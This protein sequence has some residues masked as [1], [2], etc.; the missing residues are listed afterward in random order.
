MDPRP[1][2]VPGQHLVVLLSRR[3]ALTCCFVCLRTDFCV[4]KEEPCDTVGKLPPC[5]HTHWRPHVF[6]PVSCFWEEWGGGLCLMSFCVSLNVFFCC[7]CRWSRPSFCPT[8]RV[9]SM[10]LTGM[11]LTGAGLL[12]VKVWRTWAAFAAPGGS[13]C[14][15]RTTAST[16]PSPSR[17]SWGTSEFPSQSPTI[18]AKLACSW[19]VCSLASADQLSGPEKGFAGGGGLRKKVARDL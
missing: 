13:A 1:T 15:P 8:W 3:K 5:L 17:T 19:K 16:W 11:W 9:V 18:G 7:R 12:R 2:L 14:W 4:H 6:L 10:W